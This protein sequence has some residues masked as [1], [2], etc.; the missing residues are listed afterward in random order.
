MA[1]VNE[2]LA[3]TP[4]INEPEIVVRGGHTPHQKTAWTQ[5]LA[6]ALQKEHI[7]LKASKR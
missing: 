1:Q 2:F 7:T 4:E 6:M 3:M 5:I